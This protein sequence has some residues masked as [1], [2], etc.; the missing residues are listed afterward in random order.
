MLWSAFGLGR[1][2]KRLLLVLH[3]GATSYLSRDFH[4]VL[5]LLSE[6]A[7]P[8]AVSVPVAAWYV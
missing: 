3:S 8:G 4:S 2:K 6:R 7:I 5:G 1:R